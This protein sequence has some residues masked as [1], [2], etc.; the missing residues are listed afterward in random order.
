MGD[1]TN[2]KLV[3]EHRVPQCAMFYEEEEEPGNIMQVT[4]SRKGNQGTILKERAFQ[5][6]P[7]DEEE[8]ATERVTISGRANGVGMDVQRKARH[9]LGRIGE[10]EVISV[11]RVK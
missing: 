11:A 3:K 5:P 2:N 7:Q 9:M 8:A 4:C 6:M 1:T 10:F